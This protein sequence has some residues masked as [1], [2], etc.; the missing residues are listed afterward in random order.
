M[1]RRT[2]VAAALDVASIL[3]FVAIGR[4]E[5]DDGGAS[6]AAS[7]GLLD[8]TAG[9]AAPFLLGLAVA[10]LATRGW[11]RPQS[12]VT[13]LTIWPVTVLVGM[14]ARRAL[15]DDGTAPAFVIVATLFTGLCLVGWRAVA[16]SVDARAAA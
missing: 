10:W 5:H 1:P 11:R 6:D 8:G 2:I 9:T 16:R 13:G 15:F 4:A 3:A 14:I 12:I 7:D